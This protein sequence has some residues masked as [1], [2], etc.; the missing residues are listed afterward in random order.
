MSLLDKLQSKKGKKW[1]ILYVVLCV[2]LII[3]LALIHT[4][5]PYW[6]EINS[7]VSGWVGFDFDIVLLV[8]IFLILPL[9]YGLALLIINIRRFTKLDEISPHKLNRILPIVLII[10]YIILFS[11]LLYFLDMFGEY[12]KILYVLDFYSIYFFCILDILLILLLYPIFKILPK[13]KNYLSERTIDSNKKSIIVFVCLIILYL[14]AFIF[15]IL[16][17]PTTVIYGDLSSKPYLIAHRGGSSLAP[18]NT[19]EAGIAALDYDMVV[20]WE[21]DIR[22][23]LDGVPFLMHDD[24]LLRTTNISD[25]FP[26]RKFDKAETFTISELRELDAGTWFVEKDP[27]GTISDGIISDLEAESYK[28]VKIPTFEEVLNFTRD[29][30]LYLDFDPYGPGSSHP[31]YTDFHEILLNMTIDSGVNLNKIMIPTSD[32]EWIAIINNRAPEILLGMRGSPSGADFESSPHNFSYINTGDTYSNNGYRALYK[33]NISVMVYTIDAK[34]RHSQLWCLGTKW[35]KTNTPHKF[36]DLAKP[37]WYMNIL[38]YETIWIIFIIVALSS[39]IIT[40]F[41]LNKKLEARK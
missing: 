21:V 27:F 10:F 41:V 36:N 19:I 14:F 29:N 34:E 23:S 11:V 30:N 25:H 31:F 35:V 2:N 8:R 12:K 13:I 28:G 33:S 1:I 7:E 24:T 26:N 15:P 38:V 32:S 4:I 18:E 17:I 37:L 6:Y 40:K 22:I 20:G 16:Y 39:A 5:E 9:P 3:F